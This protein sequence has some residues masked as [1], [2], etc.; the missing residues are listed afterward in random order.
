[1][2]V[3]TTTPELN[4]LLASWKS[5]NESWG[6]VP[7]MGALHEGHL[8][9]IEKSTTDDNQHTIVS[10]FVNPKQFGPNED[11]DSYPRTLDEDVA[12]ISAQFADKSIVVFAPESDVIYPPNFTTTVREDELSKKLCG[13]FREVHFTGVTTVVCR[14]LNL[15]QTNK[16]YFGQKDLQQCYIIK[17]MIENLAMTCEVVICPTV[18]EANGLAMSSRNKYLSAEQR[19]KASGIYQC[20]CWGEKQ[21]QLGEAFASVKSQMLS[22]L[23]SNFDLQYLEFVTLPDF[24]KTDDYTKHLAICAA[25]L[26]D[27]VR[28]IDN[29]RI[30]L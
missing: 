9:L 23:S 19:E 15:T 18:R 7:T 13:Q 1:M 24:K 14:L 17:R 6:F 30:Q 16:A 5:N 2:K 27:N 3:V 25:V 21:L 28:L 12:K 4:Q 10:I 11:F 20:L 26:L 22:R 8:S 29:I